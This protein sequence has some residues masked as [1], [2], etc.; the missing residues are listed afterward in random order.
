MLLHSARGGTGNILL[1][2][3]RCDSE[4]IEKLQRFAEQLSNGSYLIFI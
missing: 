3:K 2:L 1:N 4:Y